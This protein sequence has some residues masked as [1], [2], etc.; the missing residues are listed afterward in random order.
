VIYPAHAIGV[1]YRHGT[2]AVMQWIGVSQPDFYAWQMNPTVLHS[3][4]EIRFQL[5]THT[6]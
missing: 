6:G 4:I 5:S 3:F 2:G 1:G